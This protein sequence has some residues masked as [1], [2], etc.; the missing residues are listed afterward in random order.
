M[1]EPALTTMIEWL[2]PARDPRLVQLPRAE[3]DRLKAAWG[4]P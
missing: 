1:N 2:A 4:L 3:Y